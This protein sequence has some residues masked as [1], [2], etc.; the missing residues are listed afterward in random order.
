MTFEELSA[1]VAEHGFTLERG[2]EN[3]A[4]PWR[5]VWI[6]RRDG[7]SI[8]GNADTIRHRILDKQQATNEGAKMAGKRNEGLVDTSDFPLERGRDSGSQSPQARRGSYRR[9]LRLRRT[10]TQSVSKR[11]VSSPESTG[12]PRTRSSQR[13]G[14]ETL[15]GTRR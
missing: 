6:A 14:F 13:C 11:A 15:T 4:H 8:Y 5:S 9:C 7:Q 1:A 10:C 12:S 2:P 3:V